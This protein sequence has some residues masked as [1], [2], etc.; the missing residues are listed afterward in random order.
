MKPFILCFSDKFA[1]PGEV[2]HYLDEV[3][4]IGYWYRFLPNT[5]L[6]TSSLEGPMLGRLLRQRFVRLVGRPP[7]A[8][9]ILA[10]IK[11][12][13]TWGLLPYQAWELI[14]KPDTPVPK[15]EDIITATYFISI[16]NGDEGRIAFAKDADGK[17]IA[18]FFVSGKSIGKIEITDKNRKL[19]T[20]L[21]KM[22]KESTKNLLEA[23]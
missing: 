3:P 21:E 7:G 17:E 6:L 9:F 18:E 10:E 20:Y 4:E 15:R 19:I 23:D 5:I 22:K 12:A 8:G 2:Q 14:E 11:H 13:S 16:R 1:A